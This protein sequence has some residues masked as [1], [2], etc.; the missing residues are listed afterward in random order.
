MEKLKETYE[1]VKLNLARAFTNQKHYYNLRRREWIAHIGDKVMKREYSLSDAAKNFNA[2]LAP[3]YSGPYTITK[4]W[5]PVIFQL[6]DDRN[7]C[8]NKVHIKDLKPAH[9]E[10]EN[11]PIEVSAEGI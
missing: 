10:G 5:S 6:K 4:V 11:P 2:K 9:V 7:K 1:L 8:F 3:K